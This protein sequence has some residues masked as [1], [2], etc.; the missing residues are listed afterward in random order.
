MIRGIRRHKNMKITLTDEEKECLKPLIHNKGLTE[1]AFIKAAE[2]SRNAEKDLIKKVRELWPNATGIEH[3]VDGRWAVTLC[4][5]K[6]K[7]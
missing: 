4:D 3:P 6:K 5:E 2:L 7:K 1:Y